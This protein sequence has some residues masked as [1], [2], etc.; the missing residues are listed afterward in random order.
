MK[1]IDPVG[2]KNTVPKEPVDNHIIDVHCA[3]DKYKILI[4]AVLNTYGSLLKDIK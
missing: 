1:F 3:E 2:G 4:P